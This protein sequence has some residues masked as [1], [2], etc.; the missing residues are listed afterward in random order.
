MYVGNLG[1]NGRKDELEKEFKRFGKLH[2][3]WV[4][5]NPPGFAFVEFDDLR[6]AKDAI[7]ALDGK[8][9]CGARIRVEMSRHKGGRGGRSGGGGGYRGDRSGGGRHFEDRGGGYDRYDD[10]SRSPY[11]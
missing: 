3:V 9:V 1:E 10:R 4:A 11:R 5:R 8:H 6:D 2:D 7:D